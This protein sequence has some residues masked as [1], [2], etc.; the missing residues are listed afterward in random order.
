MEN[1]ASLYQAWRQAELL[2][3][4][5]VWPPVF[6]GYQHLWGLDPSLPWAC[7]LFQQSPAD[8]HQVRLNLI[9]RGETSPSLLNS[10]FSALTRACCGWQALCW[11]Q[12]WRW[13]WTLGGDGQARQTWWRV[14]KAQYA[15]GSHGRNHESRAATFTSLL[16]WNHFC[17]W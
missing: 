14:E 15:R 16:G 12:G 6:S 3:S 10:E 1:H 5:G 7:R 4:L 11:Q 13:W 2:G 17:C 8:N 9:K